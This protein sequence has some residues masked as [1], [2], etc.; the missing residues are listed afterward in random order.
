MAK[1]DAYAV[2]EV[3]YNSLVWK[4]PRKQMALDFISTMLNADGDAECIMRKV[5]MVGGDEHAE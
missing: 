5:M 3:E 2:F 1:T 4:F